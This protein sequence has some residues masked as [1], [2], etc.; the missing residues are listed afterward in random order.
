MKFYADR[1]RS[2]REFDIGDWVYLRLQP[3]QQTFVTLRRNLKLAPRF[4]GPFQVISRIGSMA[5]RL[6]LPE[7]SQIHLVFHVSQLKKMV[8]ATATTCATLLPTGSD[9]QMLVS[10]VAILD[11]KVV[12]RRNQAV[13]QVLVQWSNSTPKDATWE[14]ATMIRSH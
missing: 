9:G 2:E 6:Q 13:A 4:F 14:D 3:Y 10:P 1:N 7:S 12:K 8:G 11:R 5:Y